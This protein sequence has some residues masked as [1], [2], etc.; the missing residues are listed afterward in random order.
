[1][2]GVEAGVVG[3]QQPQQQ[4]QT[5]DNR[6]PHKRKALKMLAGLVLTCTDTCDTFVTCVALCPVLRQFKGHHGYW[7]SLTCCT[8]ADVAEVWPIFSSG[9]NSLV[10]FCQAMCAIWASCWLCGVS[11]RYLNPSACTS[12]NLRCQWVWSDNFWNDCGSAIIQSDA[13]LRF[14]VFAE[15]LKNFSDLCTCFY[16]LY[17]VLETV[18]AYS[19]ANPWLHYPLSWTQAA[20]YLISYYLLHVIRLVTIEHWFVD[21]VTFVGCVWLKR[22]C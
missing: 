13:V 2:A 22:Q 3:N 5:S 6:R 8:A 12:S 17:L 20:W 14:C 18:R 21:C 19:V 16:H 7:F 10:Y 4:E 1:M 9:P 15:C 11:H